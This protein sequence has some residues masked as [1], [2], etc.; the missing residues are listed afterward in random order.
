MSG[1]KVTRGFQNWYTHAQGHTF[2]QTEID[3]YREREKASH[4]ISLTDSQLSF[5]FLVHSHGGGE[6]RKK[7]E[8]DGKGRN[9]IRNGET[10]AGGNKS[11]L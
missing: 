6:K 2:T 10:C 1:I 8:V 7:G 5:L 3:T 11:Y 4:G 9:R